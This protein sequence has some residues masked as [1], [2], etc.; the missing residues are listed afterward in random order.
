MT[1]TGDRIIA[2]G[3]AMSGRSGFMCPAVMFGVLVIGIL[4]RATTN[5]ARSFTGAEMVAD[6]R[7]SG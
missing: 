7:H 2:T 3:I 1:I 6:W 4:C 5:I